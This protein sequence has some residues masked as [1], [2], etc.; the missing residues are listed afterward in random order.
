M[1]GKFHRCKLIAV[2]LDGTLLDDNK[3][4]PAANA[5]ALKRA[6]AR[7]IHIVMATGRPPRATN[8]V[9]KELGIE[10]LVLGSGGACIERYPSGEILCE[11]HLDTTAVRDFTLYCRERGYFIFCMKGSDYFYEGEGPAAD[12]IRAYMK[13]DGGRVDLAD[14]GLSFNKG[15]LLVPNAADT[16]RVTAE[17]KSL[18]AGRAAPVMADKDIIDINPFGVDK[19]TGLARLCELLKIYIS[20]T[21][22]FGDTDNDVE[23][24]AAA[25]L[26]VC[27]ANGMPASLACADLVAPS[28][29]NAGVAA[30]I[31]EY[32][33]D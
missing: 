1:S 2:D 31:N 24:I 32:I 26:G 27:M 14:G 10:G 22:A 4:I 28:N 17:L 18:L 12:Y 15:D 7:G 21:A 11:E 19:G 20:E 3:R 25:G 9:F 29:N 16:E 6:H 23:M 5:E 30:V 13:Y 33:L 8:W